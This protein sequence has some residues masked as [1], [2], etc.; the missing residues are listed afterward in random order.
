MVSLQSILLHATKLVFDATLAHILFSHSYAVPIDAPEL[1]LEKT[2]PKSN[3]DII[4]SLK[5]K[6]SG[7]SGIVRQED[8]SLIDGVTS[9][10]AQLSIDQKVPAKS[11]ANS[12]ASYSHLGTSLCQANKPDGIQKITAAKYKQFVSSNPSFKKYRLSPVKA[13]G[14]CAFRSLSTLIYG[15]EIHWRKV[16]QEI[17]AYACN[18]YDYLAEQL[19]LDEDDIV[20]FSEMDEPQ[21]ELLFAVAAFCYELNFGLVG[22]GNENKV[23]YCDLTEARGVDYIFFNDNHYT[24]MIKEKR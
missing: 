18:Y 19:S 9:G 14:N 22:Y 23:Y 8:P 6:R 13:E 24:P 11:P 3:A 17:S 7:T 2:L 21:G 12:V 20:E 16:K 4:E 15:S 1:Q 5:Q 10:V